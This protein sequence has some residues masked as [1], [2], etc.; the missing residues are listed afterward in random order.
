[1]EFRVPSLRDMIERTRRLERILEDDPD[2]LYYIGTGPRASDSVPAPAYP[3]NVVRVRNDSVA[4]VAVPRN[5]RE[6]RRGYY[7]YAVRMMR[8][9][10]EAGPAEGCDDAVER[11]ADLVSVFLDGWIVTRT[12]YG[13]PAL[14]AVDAMVFAREAGHLPAMLVALRDAEIR[15]CADRWASDHPEDMESYRRWR[16]SFW[17][18]SGGL[19]PPA[20]DSTPP[21]ARGLPVRRDTVPPDSVA[22]DSVRPGA[23]PP[24]TMRPDPVPPPRGATRAGG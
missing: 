1:M 19:E 8:Q 14:P 10:R 11:E 18:R 7:N 13:G 3:W 20:P 5:Y 24:D 16:E 4:E 15:D 9:V 12:L 22:P 23:V 21:E 2:V 6:A 17:G